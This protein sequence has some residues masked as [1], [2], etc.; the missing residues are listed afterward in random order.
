LSRAALA[1]SFFAPGRSLA[2]G[3]YSESRSA[4]RDCVGPALSDSG[5]S[6][7]Y[8]TTAHPNERS[9]GGW[10]VVAWIAF[11]LAFPLRSL[12][13]AVDRSTLFD[14]FV[15]TSGPSDFSASFIIGYGSSPS[16]YGP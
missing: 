2:A 6:R 10:R 13:S 11:L 16:R 15:A 7:D 8:A 4:L 1:R 9:A 5:S 3:L 14:N 12:V